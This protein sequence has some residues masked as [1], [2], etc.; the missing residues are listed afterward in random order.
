MEDF[1]QQIMGVLKDR[2]HGVLVAG[3][4]LITAVV[5]SNPQ[6]RQG[7]KRT[8]RGREGGGWTASSSCLLDVVHVSRGCR[9]Q[10]GAKYAS[11]VMA[12]KKLLR[13][14]L[15]WLS[16][17]YFSSLCS[18]LVVFKILPPCM[19][20]SSCEVAFENSRCVNAV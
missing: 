8:D 1:T 18:C 12:V 13:L 10:R 20:T 9:A 2:H 11:G 6:V 19:R 15:P 16:V 5:E 14:V 7:V 4:Q 17:L 3:V